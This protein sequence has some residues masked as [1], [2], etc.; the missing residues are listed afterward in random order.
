MWVF[1]EDY[2]ELGLMPLRDALRLARIRGVDLVECA[3]C[4]GPE[5]VC[6]LVEYRKYLDESNQRL[7]GENL[8]WIQGLKKQLGR[9]L[10][11]TRWPV[12]L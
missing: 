9:N 4:L 11:L 10:R 2:T 5:P 6:L 1:E 12:S 7:R 3:H 8:R